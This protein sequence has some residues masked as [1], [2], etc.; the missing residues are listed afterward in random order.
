MGECEEGQGR[1]FNALNA[2]VNATSLDTLVNFKRLNTLIHLKQVIHASCDRPLL[3]SPPP[4]AL[5]SWVLHTPHVFLPHTS[6][7]PHLVLVRY[8]SRLVL[9]LQQLQLSFQ[10]RQGALQLRYS[11]ESRTQLL[12]QPYLCAGGNGEQQ[13]R[14]LIMLFPHSPHTSHLCPIRTPGIAWT[15]DACISC[16]GS[17]PSLLCSPCC[18]QAER[19]HSDS[20]QYSPPH[21]ELRVRS[22]QQLLQLH[23]LK[24]S[25]QLPC[26]L[27]SCHPPI[28]SCRH[29]ACISCSG[30]LPCPL[31]GQAPFPVRPPPPPPHLQLPERCL[32]QLL[33]LTSNES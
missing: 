32:H 8:R 21:L 26:T 16:Y 6:A 14:Q 17:L 11:S 30:S 15:S 7:P 10:A 3:S 4:L 5:I 20:Q 33:Q 19:I 1:R 18:T 13:V 29:D 27:P 2:L 24:A 31:P 22:L 25:L 12:L 23:T 9:L 28:W